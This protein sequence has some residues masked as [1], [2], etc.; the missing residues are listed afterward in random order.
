MDKNHNKSQFKEGMIDS[1]PI[2]LG[3]LTV[4]FALGI[5]ARNADLTSFQGFLAS[6][7]CV[8]SSGEYAGFMLIKE[9][10]PYIEIAIMTLIANARYILMSITISQRFH[11]K[12]SFLHKLGVGFFLT[13]E[14]FAISFVK[15]RYINPYYTYGASLISVLCWAFA[16]SAGIIAGNM[17]PSSI[18]SAFSVALYGMFLA[19]VIPAAKKD[20]VILGVVFISYLSSYITDTVPFF[21]NLSDGMRIIILT[22]IISSICSIIF[23]RKVD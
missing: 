20:K 21:N 3:Y 4:A 9:K 5:V 22:I 6:I 12:T 19:I 11:E 2:A 15:N 13:D 14:I 7:L 18:V 1:I 10:A 8:S 16:T 23:P 17:L